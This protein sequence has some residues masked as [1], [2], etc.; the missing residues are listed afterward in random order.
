MNKK[1]RGPVSSARV[2]GL[3]QKRISAE[4]VQTT[5]RGLSNEELRH[6]QGSLRAIIVA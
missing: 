2:I 6:C 5:I 1:L 3:S 4:T